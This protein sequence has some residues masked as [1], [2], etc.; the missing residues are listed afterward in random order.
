MKHLQKFNELNK[1]TYLSASRGL[2]MEGH[3]KRSKDIMD[4]A[5][6]HG[7]D[8]IRERLYPHRFPNY[9]DKNEYYFVCSVEIVKVNQNSM[10]FKI[11]FKS[12]W[13]DSKDKFKWVEFQKNGDVL[14]LYR[15][16][17]NSDT[18][19]KFETREDAGHFRRFM[20]E[21]LD[22]HKKSINDNN[23]MKYDSVR[24]DISRLY[25]DSKLGKEDSNKLNN[26]DLYY[27]KKSDK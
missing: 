12:N 10:T 19:D 18:I 16:K 22:E 6:K 27:K 26:F 21:Y 14:T 17:D 9:K 4:H 5:I 15:I 3:Y 8:N 7:K 23:E 11:C 2:S 1:S 24:I 13:G 20:L 25:R